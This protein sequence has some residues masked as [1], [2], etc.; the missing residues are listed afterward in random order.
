MNPKKILLIEDEPFIQDLYKY[1]LTHA[2]YEVLVAPDGQRALSL[3]KEKFSQE[4]LDLILLDI[5]LPK[6]NGIEFLKALKLEP[7]LSKI[8]VVL[9]TNLG[10]GDIIKNAFKIGASGY[11]LKAKVGPY[12]I[13]DRIKAFIEN[14]EFKMDPE[15]IEFD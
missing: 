12:E 8:P 9:L 6:M 14:P 7:L 15:D 5:M 10:A 13:I 3:V 2:G 4:R 1:T 11:L